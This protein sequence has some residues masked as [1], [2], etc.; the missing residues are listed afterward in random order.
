MI[1][2]CFILKLGG[3]QAQLNPNI[4]TNFQQNPWN[5]TNQ[6]GFGM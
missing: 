3:I 2:N 1:N 6:T 5:N 4:Q